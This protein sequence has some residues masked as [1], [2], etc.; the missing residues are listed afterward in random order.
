[1]RYPR[2]RRADR[3]S[4]SMRSAITGLRLNGIAELPTCFASEGFEHFAEARRRHDTHV[5]RELRKRCAEAGERRKHEVIDFARIRLRRDR[6]ARSDRNLPSTSRFLIAC[7]TAAAFEQTL[8]GR[9]RTD[10]AAQALRG[11]RVVGHD[12][13]VRRRS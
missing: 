13:T 7:A 12:V 1:M 5:E 10:R 4:E 2:S 3:A 11:E 8:V 6:R 9:R